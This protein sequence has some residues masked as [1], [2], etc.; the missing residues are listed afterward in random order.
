MK[1]FIFLL[2]ILNIS[3]S[4]IDIRCNGKIYKDVEV[5]KVADNN[6]I[7]IKEAD[8]SIVNIPQKPVITN[9][10]SDNNS[11]KSDNE[12]GSLWL[13]DYI[14]AIETAKSEK[15][16]MLAD[17][18]GSDW[19]GWCKKIDGEFLSTNNF[20][21]FA[22]KNVVLFK[23]D[24]PIHIQQ[25]EALKKQNKQ[26]KDK[27]GIKGYPTILFIN[28]FNE[29]IVETISGYKKISLANYITELETIV[30]KN[31]PVK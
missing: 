26:L 23:A 20:K 28:P 2:L 18:T 7:V 9:T 24:F 25:S 14:K 22:E 3:A 1:R 8:G 5:L 30:K 13:T 10:S 27:F 12:D 29:K 6:D 16:L 4:A 31:S 15:K 21:S 19:C 11:S 17:F